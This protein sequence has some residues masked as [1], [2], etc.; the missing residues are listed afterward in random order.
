MGLHHNGANV[1][2]SVVKTQSSRLG[3]KGNST[4]EEERLAVGDHRWDSVGAGAS[5]SGSNGFPTAQVL[6]SHM[7]SADVHMVSLGFVVNESK[8]RLLGVLYG[9]TAVPQLVDNSIYAAWLQ[10][11]ILFKSTDGTV[12]W[13]V[14]NASRGVGYDK[15]QVDTNASS[16]LGRFFVYD[17]DYVTASTPG[18][19]LYTSPVVTVKEGDI[20]QFSST[21]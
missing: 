18:T 2:A 16:L 14:G 20:W 15:V 21:S 4:T 9:A 3:E 17:T 19:L 7:G 12:V 13:G 6:F 11:R 1:Y 5:G 8:T 10:R